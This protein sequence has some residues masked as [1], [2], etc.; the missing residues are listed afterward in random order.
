[1]SYLQAYQF[2]RHR[3]LDAER[4]KQ[5]HV[6]TVA[7]TVPAA[8]SVASP[9]RDAYFDFATPPGNDGA[10]EEEN[11]RGVVPGAAPAKSNGRFAGTA[12]TLVVGLILFSASTL[13]SGCNGSSIVGVR[14]MGHA[15]RGAGDVAKAAVATETVDACPTIE[16]LVD[17]SESMAQKRRSDLYQYVH[18]NVVPT[19]QPCA[20]VI[21]ETV[22]DQSTMA[23]PEI[24]FEVPLPNISSFDLITTS[25]WQDPR[26]VKEDCVQRFPEEYASFTKAVSDV[27]SRLRILLD[28]PPKSNSTFLLDGVAE[29][30]V[31]LSEETGPK[32]LVILSDSMEDSR[33]HENFH[34]DFENQT[35]WEGNKVSEL[36]AKLQ[37]SGRIPNLVGVKVY[38]V[39]AGAKTPYLFVNATE[40]WNKFFTIAGV[41]DLHFGHWPRF[42]ETRV[43]NLTVKE[44]CKTVGSGTAVAVGTVY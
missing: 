37:N 25:L 11:N 38:F 20:R 27:D 41:R 19:L 15:Q 24:V 29:A 4:R 22:V 2:A 42:Q 39:G 12:A 43:Q 8:S 16:F 36:L 3:R 28:N 14:A 33:D 13:L 23:D 30:A 7:P 5:R 34:W 21:I 6:E 17:R 26:K 44:R 31:K 35:F 10:K 32:I 18:D 9:A 1:M 40:F